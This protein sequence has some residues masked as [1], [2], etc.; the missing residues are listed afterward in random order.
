MG[1]ATVWSGGRCRQGLLALA[2]CLPTACASNRVPPTVAAPGSGRA[3]MLYLPSRRAGQPGATLPYEISPGRTGHS[4]ASLVLDQAGNGRQSGS[5]RDVGIVSPFTAMTGD[6]SQPKVPCA[7]RQ[8]SPTGAASDWR[9][10]T[11]II[12]ATPE[13]VIGVVLN[14]LEE[15][16][17]VREASVRARMTGGAQPSSGNGVVTS[18]VSQ[19]YPCNSN[20]DF[21]PVDLLRTVCRDRTVIEKI[22]ISGQPG[23]I[24]SGKLQRL[25]WTSD[26]RLWY[27]ESRLQRDVIRAGLSLADV[28]KDF[29]TAWGGHMPRMTSEFQIKT[30]SDSL[31]V[32]VVGA[33]RH[34]IGPNQ[35]VI[36]I[37]IYQAV[38]G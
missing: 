18:I 30:T 24:E 8:C 23:S 3:A 15:R 36:T 10:R 9:P 32:A 16:R 37:E 27:D 19:L 2:I 22:S 4:I 26:I 31:V 11:A 28:S 1:G 13:A 35:D 20:W 6:A 25:D 17:P 21:I 38:G 5:T 14:L 29:G 34:P 12:A 33:G 7:P